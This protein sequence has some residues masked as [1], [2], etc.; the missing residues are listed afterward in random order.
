[1]HKARR[2]D[3]RRNREVILRAA[4]EAFTQGSEAVP[5][6]EI[7]RRAGLGRATVYRHFPDRHALAGAVAKRQLAE[8]RRIVDVEDGG[9][10]FRDLLHG[11]LCDQVSRR[12]LVE[13]FCELPAHEQ[14]RYVN[15]LIEVLTPPFRRAQ[16]EGRLRA[17]VQ[18]ADIVRIV[19]MVE[20]VVTSRIAP[21]DAAVGAHK[22]IEITLDG[23]C[24]P[25]PGR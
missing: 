19:E 4:D 2:T 17:D 14:R 13:L 3:A 10:S 18:P 20:A 21:A 7:A 6:E 5:L 1:M 12:P 9:R 23:L 16:A 11:V 15:A 25:A 22:L 24:G 8:W